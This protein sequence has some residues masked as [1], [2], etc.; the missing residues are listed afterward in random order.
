MWGDYHLRELGVLA[1]RESRS[2]PY[3][4]FFDPAH[5]ERKPAPR[6]PKRRHKSKFT[7]AGTD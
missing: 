3:P 4:T 7:Y 6:I 1:L 2:E 5:L